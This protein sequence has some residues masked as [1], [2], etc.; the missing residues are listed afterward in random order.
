L[1]SEAE[2]RAFADYVLTQN[3]R[4]NVEPDGDTWAVWIL[5]EDQV[6]IAKEEL[7]AFRNDPGAEKYREAKSKADA[8][9]DKEI[10]RSREVKKKVVRANETWNQSSMQRSPVTITLIAV[11]VAAV[12]MTTPSDKPFSFG[13]RIEPA[14]T[15]LAL[16]PIQ[17]SD[18]EGYVSI[19]VNTFEAVFQ[20]EVWRLFTPM[21]LHF[22]FFHLFFNMMWLKDLGGAVEARRGRWRF[23]L[24][25]LLIAGISN[26]AQGVIVRVVRLRLDAKPVRSQF[27]VLHAAKPR[28]VHAGLHGDLLRG[29]FPANRQH[30]TYGRPGRRHDRRVRTQSLG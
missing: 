15:W 7:T 25:V 29:R 9:R 19:P 12:M 30:R 14:L 4:T 28:H 21:F 23:L 20:G 10:Q 8:L 22:H 2:A 16:A 6:P 24:L 5:E 27:R 3:I 11:S 26:A 17:E 18:R 13:T 1:P